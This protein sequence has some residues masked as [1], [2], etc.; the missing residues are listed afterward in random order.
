[1]WYKQRGIFYEQKGTGSDEKN[2]RKDCRMKARSRRDNAAA[3]VSF[4]VKSD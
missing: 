4:L 1:V 3:S 2:N